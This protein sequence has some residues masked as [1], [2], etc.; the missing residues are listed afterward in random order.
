MVFDVC[1]HF[2]MFSFLLAWF[3]SVLFFCVCSIFS[4]EG[5]GILHGYAVL[6]RALCVII[7]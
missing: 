1:Y 5:C 7:V 3:G 6:Y 4:G 2:C